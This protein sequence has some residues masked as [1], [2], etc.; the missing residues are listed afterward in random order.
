MQFMY[1]GVYKLMNMLWHILYKLSGIWEHL[2]MEEIAEKS[3][4]ISI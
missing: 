2:G 4:C 1:N 3:E